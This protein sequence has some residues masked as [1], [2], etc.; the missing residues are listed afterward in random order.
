MGGAEVVGATAPEGVRPRR[1]GDAQERGFEGSVRRGVGHAAAVAAADEIARSAR[2]FLGRRGPV[3]W[4]GQPL[5]T[6]APRRR[7]QPQISHLV[8]ASCPAVI[9]MAW[10]G[11][12]SALG[13]VTDEAVAEWTSNEA[14]PFP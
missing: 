14:A 11:R 4:A 2:T 6:A 9:Q 1:P 5:D 13:A 10:S 7:S 8:P 12:E 3:N